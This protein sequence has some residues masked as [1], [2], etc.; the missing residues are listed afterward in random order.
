MTKDE[1]VKWAG[2][3]LALIEEVAA[4]AGKTGK[5]LVEYISGSSIRDLKELIDLHLG[6]PRNAVVTQVSGNVIQV[7]FGA[8]AAASWND[9]ASYQDRPDRR[10]R[11]SRLRLIPITVPSASLNAHSAA[12]PSTS[13]DTVVPYS[14]C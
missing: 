8:R 6:A 2:A 9:R 13:P 7:N 14:S 4:L 3:D 10:A 11:G 1:Y 5:E 12:V